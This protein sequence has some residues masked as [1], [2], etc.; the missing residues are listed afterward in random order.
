MSS[1]TNKLGFFGFGCVGEGTYEILKKREGSTTTDELSLRGREQSEAGTREANNSI[2]ENDEVSISRV[3]ATQPRND[4]SRKAANVADFKKAVIKNPEKERI[5]P[6]EYFTTVGEEILSDPEIG[7]IAELIDGADEAY[8]IVRN[9]LYNGKDVVSANKKMIAENFAKL[10][11]L[12]GRTG[13]KLLYEA[14]ACGSIPIIRTLDAHFGNEKIR[15]ISGIFN[16]SSNF[17]LTKLMNAAPPSETLRVPAGKDQQPQGDTSGGQARSDNFVELD[18][19]ELSY[20]GREQSEAWTRETDVSSVH[21]H[22]SNDKVAS[23]I[24]N[25]ST[26]EK[27]TFAS[28]LKEAQDLGF[29]ETDPT[30]DIEGYDPSYKLVILIAHAF[31][32]I[33]KP[34]DVVRFGISNIAESDIQFA[35][36]NNLKIKQIAQAVLLDDNNL[37]V[38]VMP[39]FVFPD[40][41][42]Y[43]VDYEFNAVNIQPEFADAQFLYGKGAGSLPT[44]SAVVAD[45]DAL[46]RG[47]HYR[48]EKLKDSKNNFSINEGLNLE[49][50]IG[51]KNAKDIDGLDIGNI[52]YINELDDRKYLVAQVDARKLN[53]IS[54]EARQR[55]LFVAFTGNSR[56]VPKRTSNRKLRVA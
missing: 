46:K 43:H 8:E 6:S 44:G 37:Q 22:S 10:I 14:S 35:R 27:V 3:P 29:A 47:E 51:Y 25:E 56:L 42:L 34:S 55:G 38:T 1:S 18:T 53:A 21:E 13:R 9:A 12:Q 41:Q 17:I 23:Y 5:L 28:V 26:S 32:Q 19:D 16:G 36:D 39:Q 20:R 33:I 2:A 31:G 40:S 54:S 4:T 49:V 24:D 52:S 7:T 48:Y 15:S 30:L 50:Y 11:Q 45:L